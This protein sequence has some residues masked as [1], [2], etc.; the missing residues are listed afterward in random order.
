MVGREHPV[1]PTPTKSR[2]ALAKALAE[3]LGQLK[4]TFAR[5]AG[6][7]RFWREVSLPRCS[8][9]SDACAFRRR[10][11]A[12]L[13][14]SFKLFLDAD[15]KLDGRP[16]PERLFRSGPSGNASATA[17]SNFPR[18]SPTSGC[19]GALGS[20]SSWTWRRSPRNR[21]PRPGGMAALGRAAADRRKA[22][23]NRRRLETEMP[24]VRCCPSCLSFGSCYFHF[25][26][27]ICRRL[28]RQ[29][30]HGAARGVPATPTSSGRPGP[31]NQACGPYL[32]LCFGGARETRI[33]V[34]RFDAN[35]R[36]Y[37]SYYQKQERGVK[38]TQKTDL[39]NH[40][41]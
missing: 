35:F 26:F 9:R 16:T 2:Q 19:S 18:A 21:A 31:G 27:D 36:Y 34:A 1:A 29:I 20:K 13:S 10:L 28:R 30:H 6:V 12:H 32:F 39:G 15:A 4:D 8:I 5:N 40:P 24:V 33:R 23:D 38:N 37:V 22:A 7:K 14:F 41:M 17:S 3:V 11:R 25:L